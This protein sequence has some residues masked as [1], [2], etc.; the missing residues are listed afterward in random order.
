MPIYLYHCET[1][2]FYIE[3]FAVSPKEKLDDNEIYCASCGNTPKRIYNVP[4]VLYKTNGFYTT[5]N[6]KGENN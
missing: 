4:T 6:P 5:D 1:C 3:Q 2:D